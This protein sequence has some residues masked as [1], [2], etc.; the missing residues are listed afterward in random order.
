MYKQ[1][2][3]KRLTLLMDDRG[4]TVERGGAV[5]GVSDTMIKRYR[6]GQNFPEGEEMFKMADILNV[7]LD[8]LG[9]RTDVR[10]V[11]KILPDGGKNI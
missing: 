4:W 8:W 7:S 5:F 11:C 3:G 6:A 10:E 1:I 9:G 2:F